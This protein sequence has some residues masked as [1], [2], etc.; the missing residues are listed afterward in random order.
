MDYE[1]VSTQPIRIVPFITVD[2]S[3]IIDE[4]SERKTT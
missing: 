4:G 2:I 3:T 1:D